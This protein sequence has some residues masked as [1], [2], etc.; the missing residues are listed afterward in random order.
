[1]QRANGISVIGILPLLFLLSAGTL[2]GENSKEAKAELAARKAAAAKAAAKAKTTAKAVQKAQEVSAEKR[3]KAEKLQ[4]IAT[5]DKAKLGAALNH[6][7]S[8]KEI[9]KLTLAARKSGD[10]AQKSQEEA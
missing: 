7:A 6:N 2:L 4:E 8:Q 9:E 3:I 5:A 10:A 1:M